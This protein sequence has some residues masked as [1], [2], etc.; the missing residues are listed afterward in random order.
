MRIIKT[1]Y[2]S[3]RSNIN[4]FDIIAFKGDGVTSRV[5]CQATDSNVSHVGLALK[6]KVL[7]SNSDRYILNIVESTSLNGGGGVRIRRLSDVVNDYEGRVWHI[8]AR[9]AYVIP[10]D[11]EHQHYEEAVDLLLN[12]IGK[13]YDFFQA[14]R[15]AKD[16]FEGT[17][18]EG[19]DTNDEC[20]EKL[21]CSELCSAIHQARGWL[22]T[23]VNASE[24]TPIDVC[25]YLYMALDD[26]AQ[27]KGA[28]LALRPGI[29][30]IFIDGEQSF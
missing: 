4:D 29:E 27:I 24:A 2:K 7:G 30:A 19:I 26:I 15:S 13:E 10:E 20:L 9:P 21:F 25:E 16:R 23:E 22:D 5:I 18:M 1:D 28:A 3:I 17:W 8:P 14:A 11:I 6:T 12:Q